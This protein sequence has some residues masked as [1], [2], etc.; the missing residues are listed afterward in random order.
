MCQ[1]A[2]TFV[3]RVTK[4]RFQKKVQLPIGVLR[5]FLS[6]SGLARPA[7]EHGASGYLAMNLGPCGLDHAS[8]NK[9]YFSKNGDVLKVHSHLVKRKTLN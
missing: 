7:R 8:Y 9:E 6:L 3:A 2:L 1:N 4:E 5:L